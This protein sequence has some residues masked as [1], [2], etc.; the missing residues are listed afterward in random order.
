MAI[1]RLPEI[2]YPITE[3]NK[4]N[5]IVDTLN[6]NLG[7]YY[8]ETNPLL[9]P[10]NGSANWI[11]NHNLGT[12]NV[13][14]SLYDGDELVVSKIS[15]T[16]DN[17]VTVSINAD[18][19]IEADTYKIIVVA[20][21]V[22]SASGNEL[23][24]DST[25][26]TTSTNPVQNKV[27]TDAINNKLNKT[28]VDSTL[29]STSTNPVQNKVIQTVLKYFKL[30][31]G[32]TY[33]TVRQDGSGDFTDIQSALNY[34]QGTFNNSYIEINIGAGTY[35]LTN[36]E[37]ARIMDIPRTGRNAPLIKI[38]GAS[39]E[40]TIIE[41][42]TSN[43]ETEYIFQTDWGQNIWFQYLT[44]KNSAASGLNRGGICALTGSSVQITDCVFEGFNFIGVLCQGT[45]R[46]QFD[47]TNTFKNFTSTAIHSEAGFVNTKYGSTLNFTNT[48]SGATAFVVT[49]GGQIHL[50]IG[51]TVN[52]TRVTR[53]NVS[54]G[55]ASNTGWITTA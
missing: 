32:C 44:L 10:I 16:S 39:P 15:I 55:S 8:S 29:S 22:V 31:G 47:G 28:A 51:T 9:T 11:V 35:T 13:T 23:V 5:E 26:S 1:D 54:V 3:V 2:I 30:S 53:A 25:L 19:D 41:G 4:V 52:L 48:T 21:G 24:I 18:S 33:V 7:M 43:P 14:C 17:S 50:N 42:A 40:S 6:D 36:Y 12:Q 34:V 27:V 46:V 38:I 49:Y 20:N 37:Y 45:S